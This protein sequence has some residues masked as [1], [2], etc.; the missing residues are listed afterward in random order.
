M[1][2][3]YSTNICVD[4]SKKVLCVGLLCL[5]LVSTCNEFPT[6]GSD[7]RCTS[8]RWQKG[9][10]AAN[11]STVLGILK[12]NVEYFGSVSNC[13]SHTGNLIAEYVENEMKECNVSMD[14]V[15]VNKNCQ[16][17]TSQVI[18][19]NKNGSRTIVHYGKSLP[20]ITLENFVSL[21][22]SNYS[23]IH[24]EGRNIEEVL[25][26]MNYL[27]EYNESLA[28][29]E[30]IFVSVETEKPSRK[31]QL[32]LMPLADLVV[33]SQDFAEA[34]NYKTACE[35]VIAF[36]SYCKPG[37]FVV[38][39][40]GDS[41]AACGVAGNN[42]DVVM[43]PAAVPSKVVDTLG[44]GDTFLGGLIYGLVQGKSLVDSTQLA[45][46]IAGHKVSSY[47]YRHIKEFNLK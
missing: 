4:K 42:D 40:W 20:D 41:G 3:K 11:T 47:G 30:K 31:K 5:D 2:T 29:D 38:C 19:N 23:V 27:K 33:V 37:A 14:N 32:L 8:L 45:C 7:Q 35:A 39:A 6:E 15:V 9:G 1:S 25:K 12:Q 16:T 28:K 26:M 17:P 43:V 21:N 36:K 13:S 44:A 24:F 10:N 34:K 22:H 18:I 46:N